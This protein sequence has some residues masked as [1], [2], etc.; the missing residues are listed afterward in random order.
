[1]IDMQKHVAFFERMR[2]TTFEYGRNDCALFCAR[3][4]IE[5]HGCPDFAAE[6]RG[7]YRTEEEAFALIRDEGGLLGM[8]K[9]HLKQK[10]L[11][12][13]KRGDIAWRQFP[14]GTEGVG[15]LF[16]PRQ[17]VAP[18]DGVT[19]GYHGWPLSDFDAVFE[20]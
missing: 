14:D 10:A 11:L 15:V 19:L 20:V 9:K 5:V 6:F 13:A 4:L 18:W 16:S 3:Y 1:M 12:Q 8:C 2:G 7:K 17:V